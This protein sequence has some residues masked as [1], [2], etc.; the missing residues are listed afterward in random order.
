MCYMAIVSSL[1]LGFHSLDKVKE[2][3]SRMKRRRNN[4]TKEI[5]FGLKDQSVKVLNS[6]FCISYFSMYIA[7]TYTSCNW[8]E[9]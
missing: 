8:T 3:R 5:P 6:Q 1:C 7:R 4:K 2:W 9:D